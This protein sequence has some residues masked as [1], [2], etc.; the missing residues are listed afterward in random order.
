MFY[1]FVYPESI[2]QILLEHFDRDVGESVVEI[3]KY[4]INGV[5]YICRSHVSSMYF[6]GRG[7]AGERTYSRIENCGDVQS[8]VGNEGLVKKF[9]VRL[10][11]F[12]TGL[13]GGMPQECRDLKMDFMVGKV[14]SSGGKRMGNLLVYRDNRTK[15]VLADILKKYEMTESEPTGDICLDMIS[16][17][18]KLERA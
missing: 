11:R 3:T 14:F 2:D 7:E 12:G 16:L 8:I 10:H 6:V 9:E 4:K 15:R 18:A 1:C 5:F 17:L 13:A